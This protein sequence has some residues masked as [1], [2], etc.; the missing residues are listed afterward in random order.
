MVQKDKKKIELKIKLK[1]L[2]TTI[3]KPKKRR[4]NKTKWKK[5][6]IKKPTS[7]RNNRISVFGL[8]SGFNPLASRSG[9]DI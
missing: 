3:L 9:I 2:K 6:T 7:F 4:K 5:N 8:S 1:I